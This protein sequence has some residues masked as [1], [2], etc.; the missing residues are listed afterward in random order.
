MATNF[1]SVLLERILGIVQ[2]IFLSH[3]SH[4]LL[5]CPDISIVSNMSP[6][7]W[8]FTHME[9]LQL[10]NNTIV[11]KETFMVKNNFSDDFLWQPRHDEEFGHVMTRNEAKLWSQMVKR[12]LPVLI[13]ISPKLNKIWGNCNRQCYGERPR[14]VMQ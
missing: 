2:Y 6:V 12:M 4:A 5:S 7:C 10:K 3:F 9:K 1:L 11:K 13:K 8:I 14:K